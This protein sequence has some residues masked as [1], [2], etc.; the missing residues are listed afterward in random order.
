M[1][2]AASISYPLRFQRR[3]AQGAPLAP[4][5]T[6][7]SAC[8]LRELCIPGGLEKRE[9]L[10]LDG[11]L[12]GRRRVKEGQPLYREGDAFHYLYSARS[13]TFKSTVTLV[14]GREQVTG[15]HMAGELMGLDALAQATHASAATA[16]EDAEICAIPYAH[17]SALAASNVKLQEALARM[18]SREIVRE[19]GWM[20]LLGSMSAE[21]R[22]ASFLLNIS[23]RMKARGFA[24]REFHLRMS[25]AEIGSFLGMKLE[26]VSRTLSS[27][28][29]RKLLVVDKRFVR[30]VDL[31]ALAGTVERRLR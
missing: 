25:R 7:C 2:A 8:H 27:L 17:L 22:V 21:E 30:I 4:R 23:Q 1:Q 5:K 24:A 19:H 31:E 14:D 26:T 6:S 29:A 3:E 9:V 20:A 10:L 28:H 13:G 15:F 12:I 11:L 18:M 16:L